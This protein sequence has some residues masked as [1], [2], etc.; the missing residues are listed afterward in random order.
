MK[1]KRKLIGIIIILILIIA[2][3]VGAYLY[4]FTD[5]FKSPEEAFYKYLGKM[6]RNDLSY[7][8][9][10]DQIKE[11]KSKNFKSNSTVGIELKTKG[12]DYLSRLNQVT[13]DEVSKLKLDVETKN[14]PSQNKTSSNISLKYNDETLTE[15]KLVKGENIYGLQSEFLDEKYIAIEN[16][17][18]KSL[19]RKFGQESVG[20]PDQIENI[21]FY[22][23][24]YI[25]KADKDKIVNDY[26]DVIKNSISS[27]KFS[28]A[29]NVNQKINGEV[30]NTKTISLKMTVKEFID[31]IIKVLEK[32][33]KDEKTLDILFD[34]LNKIDV[35]TIGTNYIGASTLNTKE[36]LE[37]VIK[38]IIDKLN[39][40]KEQIV[41]NKDVEI[42]LYIVDE[43]VSRVEFKYN[44]EVKNAIECYTADNKKHL[45][46]YTTRRDEKNYSYYMEE[47]SREL[48]K[49]I[50]IEYSINKN[51]SKTEFAIDIFDNVKVGFELEKQNENKNSCRITIETKDIAIA[52]NAE[53][54]INYEDDI[55]IEDLDNEN[56]IVLNNMNKEEMEKLF[57]NIKDTFQEKI[58]DKLKGL[59]VIS[60]YTTVGINLL[61][62]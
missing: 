9:K 27:D 14:V 33:E 28:K 61:G 44:N 21:D 42:V 5:M 56:S 2:V 37:K 55:Q 48:R 49:V 8:E 40:T 35:A 24:L 32:L 36:D 18:L 12:T 30:K 62:K 41:D 45:D 25:S 50:G 26:S 1:S 52:L 29:D 10:L 34:K 54:N 38:Q 20:I 47:T 11:M 58:M 4:F 13:Y 43:E 6:A 51:E 17:N 31:V 39:D 57:N 3:G 16:K 59:G 15:L 60:P 46:F 19:V 23:L 22:D 7:Q 53:T